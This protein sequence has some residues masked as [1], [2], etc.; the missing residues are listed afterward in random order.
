M[1]MNG[2]FNCSEQSNQGELVALSRSWL[3]IM[4]KSGFGKSL[5]GSSDG[6]S[7]ESQDDIFLD[8][9]KKLKS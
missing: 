1:P 7:Y 6:I 5:N 2:A 4:S 9:L 3:S 8:V